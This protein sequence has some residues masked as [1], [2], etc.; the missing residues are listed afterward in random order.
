MLSSP[1]SGMNALFF[2]RADNDEVLAREKVRTTEMVWA[3]SP[4]LGLAGATYAGVLYD[5][6]YC[7]QVVYGMEI[8]GSATP[9]MDD[10]TLELYNVDTIVTA[11]VDIV[12]D[13]LSKIPQGGEGGAATPDGADIMLP[14]GCDFA[15]ENAGTFYT[16]TDKLIHWLNVDGRVNVSSE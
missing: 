15:G 5:Q 8:G 9:I 11:V 12:N 16:N 13:A 7:S 10:P 4:S 1:I 14:F 2:M 3:P 6:T